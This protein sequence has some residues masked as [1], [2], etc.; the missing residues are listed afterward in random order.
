[1]QTLHQL[2]QCSLQQKLLSSNVQQIKNQ[3]L[4][5]TDIH[6]D[7]ADIATNLRVAHKFGH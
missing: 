5:A 7:L 2:L 6:M 3:Q 1:L 4:Q